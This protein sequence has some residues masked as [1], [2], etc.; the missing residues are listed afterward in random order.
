MVFVGIWGRLSGWISS[1]SRHMIF[2]LALIVCK[3]LVPNLYDLRWFNLGLFCTWYMR[4][5]D[6]R[7]GCDG[8]RCLLMR[9]GIWLV[10]WTRG[11]WSACGKQNSNPGYLDLK[12]FEYVIL[13]GGKAF[14]DVKPGPWDVKIVLNYSGGIN[15]IIGMII[16]GRQ[17]GEVWRW[18]AACCLWR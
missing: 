1:L 5:G 17:A 9:D 3:A 7:E 18:S 10:G 11:F 13:Y 4:F 12:I 2:T 6:L 14:A 15:V 16:K 8:L